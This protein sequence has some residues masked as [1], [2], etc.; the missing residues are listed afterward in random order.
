MLGFIFGCWLLV[1][2]E[3]RSLF[4]KEHR[5]LTTFASGSQTPPTVSNE[6]CRSSWVKPNHSSVGSDGFGFRARTNALVT[7]LPILIV[8][9]H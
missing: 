3:N 2:S 8:K 6:F 9:F 4:L 1:L 7:T 5:I